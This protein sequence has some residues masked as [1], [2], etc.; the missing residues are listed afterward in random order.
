[1]ENIEKKNKLLVQPNILQNVA[2][3]ELV[4]VIYLNFT[5]VSILPNIFFLN[6]TWVRKIPQN[7]NMLS[8]ILKK[9]LEKSL[10]QKCLKNCIKD[11]F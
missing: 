1:V 11:C 5:K 6:K 9:L 10:R 4:I 7:S 2:L 8:K 3:C